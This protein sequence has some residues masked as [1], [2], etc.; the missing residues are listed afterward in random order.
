MGLRTWK[1]CNEDSVTAP[2]N[3]VLL[4]SPFISHK[5]FGF[6]SL[7]EGRKMTRRAAT[8]GPHMWNQNRMHQ[9][10]VGSRIFH[11]LIFVLL[12]YSFQ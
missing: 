5:T 2:R 9:G 8:P 12:R 7:L 3:H 4:D 1:V 10:D 11:P 6:I